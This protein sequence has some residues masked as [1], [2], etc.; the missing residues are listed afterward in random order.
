MTFDPLDADDLVTGAPVRV[1]ARRSGFV[2]EYRMSF[3]DREGDACAL[4]LV[5]RLDD[6]TLRG[7][8]E[9]A[10]TLDREVTRPWGRARLR[11]D[12]RDVALRELWLAA[13][14][15]IIAH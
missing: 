2:V 14:Q 3:S 7:W 8:T 1:A 15:T 5:Q 10:G 12:Y 13:R 9:L 11:L 6:W 4:E